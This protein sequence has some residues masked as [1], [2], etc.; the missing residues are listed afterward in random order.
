M[1]L[2]HGEYGGERILSRDSVEAMTTDQLTPEQKAVSGFYPGYF[3]TRGWGFGVAIAT[4]PD[5]VT[6]V[7]G[8]FGWNGGFGTSW[9]T[10]P[11][12][13]LVAMLLTQ[14]L[15]FPDVWDL[16]RDF[17]TSAYQSLQD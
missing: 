9:V 11:G 17:W 15:G 8:R 3:D 16:Y 4:E 2:D 14:R 7:P 10:D 6:T 13:D 12:Q 1:L 5:D